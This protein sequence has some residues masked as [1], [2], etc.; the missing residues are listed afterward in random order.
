MLY[1]NDWHAIKNVSKGSVIAVLASE[2]YDSKDYITKKYKM[3][4]ENLNKSNKLFYP[5]FIN[6]LKKI[7][8]NGA[9]ILGPNVVKFENNFLNILAP[10][11]L[12][13]QMVWMLLP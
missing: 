12:E 9:Y 4:Y 13:W 6:S 10:I 7:N 8:K 3:F 11:M 1:P 5:E 2:Y